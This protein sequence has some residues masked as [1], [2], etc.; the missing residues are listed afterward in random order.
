MTIEEL[1]AA[2]SGES[3]QDLFDLLLGE[4]ALLTLAP[5]I[6]AL[7]EAV[8]IEWLTQFQGQRPCKRL[9]AAI[10]AFNAKLA[11]L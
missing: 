2:V 6:L 11:Q 3:A 8:D 5:E 4:E 1:K 10:D 9:F 7:V